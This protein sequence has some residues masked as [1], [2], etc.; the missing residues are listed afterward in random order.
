MVY[1]S[2]FNLTKPI[3]DF[4]LMLI[5]IANSKLPFLSNIMFQYK[6]KVFHS[7]YISLFTSAMISTETIEDENNLTS[8]T[9]Y[10][11]IAVIALLLLT[12]YLFFKK[13]EQNDTAAKKRA[14]RRPIKSV[15]S[16]MASS[17]I[18]SALQS[19]PISM[20][21]SQIR[22]QKLAQRSRTK[23]RKN[24]LRSKINKTRRYLEQK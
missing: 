7:S 6:E 9:I 11:A 10:L 3:V 22:T 23:K 12:I 19:T 1:I 2:F 15:I 21:G 17:V 20:L 24:R 4:H 8:G 13:Y 18:D 16:K 5:F 14:S